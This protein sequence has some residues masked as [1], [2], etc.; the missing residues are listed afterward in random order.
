MTF[1]SCQKCAYG[2]TD[3]A[4]AVKHAYKEMGIDV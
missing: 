2:T 1:W 3:A 4:E